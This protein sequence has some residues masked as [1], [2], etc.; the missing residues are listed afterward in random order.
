MIPQYWYDLQADLNIELDPLIF[1]VDNREIYPKEILES[2]KEAYVKIPEPVMK[3]YSKYRPTPLA[4]AYELERYIGA[5][6]KIFYKYEGA[7]PVGSHKLN[8]AIPQA[9][10]S[11]QN[12]FS[13][14]TTAT[15]AGQWGS[16]IS[17]AA[18]QFSLKAS[19]FFVSISMQQKPYRKIFMELLGADVFESPSP[20]TSIGRK[21]R[22]NSQ[23]LTGNMGLATSE[24]IEYAKSKN[25]SFGE[26]SHA[27]GVILHQTVIGQEAI[28]Q[29]E[30][31]GEYPDILIG[32]V[33]GGT[34]FGGLS[35]PFLK[36]KLANKSNMR[37]IAVEPKANSTL[38][39]GTY[40]YDY[41]DTSKLTPQIKMYTLGH[42]HTPDP[43][44][45]GGLRYHGFDPLLSKLYNEGHIEAQAYSQKEIFEAGS[46]FLKTE[47]ILPAPESAHAIRASIYEAQ[48]EENKGKTIL[49]CLSGHGY[50][51]LAG[52]DYYMKNLT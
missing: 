30:K 18:Q 51:D 34:N 6:C 38:L 9:Y 26:T 39:E 49:F 35:T 28:S 29:L 41:A 13:E 33:G 20:I 40:R 45:A 24:S 36:N 5:K 11:V 32:C 52:Y 37:F 15:G 50:F 19:I 48:K 12:G 8:T 46:L 27:R 22:E 25:A 31:M 44:H 10:Y 4:R 1:T 42:D 3:L 16:A 43:I 23:N 7:N 2:N 21:I 14:I 47:G 17:Y